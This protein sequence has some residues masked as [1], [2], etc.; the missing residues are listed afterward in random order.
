LLSALLALQLTTASMFHLRRSD[1]L[2]PY[3]FVSYF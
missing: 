2:A 3:V 1:E